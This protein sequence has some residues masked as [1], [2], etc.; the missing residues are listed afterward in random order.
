MPWVIASSHLLNDA[1]NTKQDFYIG[2]AHRQMP[3]VILTA[4]G[5][6]NDSEYTAASNA[7]SAFPLNQIN[8]HRAWKSSEI[9]PFLGH[10]ALE[11]LNC[12]SAAYTGSFIRVLVNSSPKPL[13]GCSDGPGASCPLGQYMDYIKQRNELFEDFSKAC[14]VN[15]ENTTDVLIFS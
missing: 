14:G 7:N 6:Y 9:I 15:Y 11:R 2:V 5:L 4:L 12:M 10:V 13:P 8:Y 1:S 3:P